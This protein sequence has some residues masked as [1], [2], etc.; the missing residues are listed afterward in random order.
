MSFVNAHF[1]AYATD[2]GYSSMVAAWGYSVVGIASIAGAVVLGYL[3]DEYGRKSYLSFS[4]FLRLIG[5][6]SVLLSMGVPLFGW[7]PL[8]LKALVLGMIMVGL[9]WNSVVGITAAYASDRF[10][11][12]SFATIYGT[13]FAAMPFGAGLGASISGYFYDVRVSYDVAIWMNIFLLIIAVFFA[14]RT[15]EWSA[16]KKETIDS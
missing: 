6:I 8:G 1:V 14:M 16:R 10:G 5:F 7:G 13:M 4:Y 15:N 2:L 3:S 9:S 12:R 11:T